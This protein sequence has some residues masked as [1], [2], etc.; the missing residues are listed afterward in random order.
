VGGGKAGGYVKLSRKCNA[1]GAVAFLGSKSDL[2]PYYAAADALVLP[3]FYDP[4]SLSVLEAAAG[5][6]PCVT[7]RFNGAGELLTDGMDGFVLTDPADDALL[8]DRLGLLLD[9][10]LRESMGNAARQMALQHTLDDNCRRIVEIYE[11][12]VETKSR[13]CRKSQ[14]YAAI[15]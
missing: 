11:E 2:A 4:C 13:N 3:T 10:G 12:I 1:A 8:S 14:Q 5:G 6:L 9:S 15:P 7:T